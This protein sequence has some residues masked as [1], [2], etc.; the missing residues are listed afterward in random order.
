MRLL[1]GM[2]LW[3]SGAAD[4]VAPVI[5]E[6]GLVPASPPHLDA[7]EKRQFMRR[8]ASTHQD[9]GR[10]SAVCIL[11]KHPFDECDNGDTSNV[12]LTAR[13]SPR[14]YDRVRATDLKPGPTVI[15]DGVQTHPHRIPAE[16]KDS[17]DLAKVEEGG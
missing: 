11:L 7:L 13:L 8:E 6:A 12:V 10:C 14:W 15:E 1:G 17:I 2:A 5:V 3:G 9:E 4:R 16:A